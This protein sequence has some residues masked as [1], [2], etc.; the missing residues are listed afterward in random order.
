MRYFET[1]DGQVYGFTQ[2]RI[3]PD[4]KATIYP[5]HIW[6]NW[7]HGRPGPNKSAI[8]MVMGKMKEITKEQAFIVLV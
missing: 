7:K 8:I 2:K 6:T 1:Q 4:S 3:R 5:R